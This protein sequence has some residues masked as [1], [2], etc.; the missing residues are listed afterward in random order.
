LRD[1]DS[2]EEADYE[3]LVFKAALHEAARAVIAWHQGMRVVQLNLPEYLQGDSATAYSD[4]DGTVSN[5]TSLL[6]LCRSTEREIRVLLAGPIAQCIFCGESTK[7]TRTS[8]GFKYSICR[9]ERI[10]DDASEIAPTIDALMRQAAMLVRLRWREINR[11]AM[12]LQR[13]ERLSSADFLKV[14][15]ENPYQAWKAGMAIQ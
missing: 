9:I 12:S 11:V 15:S 2:D 6:K 10:V 5:V 7:L 14:L 13:A 8:V 1:D 3:F 4:C